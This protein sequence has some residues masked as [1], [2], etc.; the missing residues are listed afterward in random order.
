MPIDDDTALGELLDA[1]RSVA[2]IGIKDGLADDAY[3]VP[4]YLQ[5]HGYRI[6]PVSPKLDRVL[7]EPCVAR[8]GDLSETP[9]LVN[10]FRAPAHV[11]GHVDEI[12]ALAGRPRAVWM[13]LGIRHDDTARA[14]TEAGI[15]VVQDRC[16]LVEH[17]A[18]AARG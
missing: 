10:L 3:R 5:R 12:L 14:L 7:G 17:R 1:V 6:L 16:I 13:Q 9:D 15:D 11:P 18:A 2:V 8:L 4:L